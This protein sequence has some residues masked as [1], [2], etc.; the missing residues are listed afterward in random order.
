MDI[1]LLYFDGCPNWETTDAHLRILAG[2]RPDLRVT[3]RLVTT[4]EDAQATGF[5]GS[6]SVLVNGIDAFADPD[7]PVGLTCR[8][9]QTPDG[10]AG[11]PTLAQ[12]HEVLDNG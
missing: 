8:V 1:T 7:A 6:P 11:S 10:P 9:F 2:E 12:L 3:R 4:P 5:R